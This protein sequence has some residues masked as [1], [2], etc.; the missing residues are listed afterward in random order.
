MKTGD[1]LDIHPNMS[2]GCYEAWLV[3]PHTGG[4]RLFSTCSLC[5]PEEQVRW[6]NHQVCNTLCQDQRLPTAA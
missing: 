3:D 2:N 4:K 6:W 1:Q 5:V